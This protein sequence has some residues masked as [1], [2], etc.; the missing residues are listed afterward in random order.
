MTKSTFSSSSYIS[1]IFNI[2]DYLT[3]YFKAYI[4][5]MD[6]N[7]LKE[8]YGTNKDYGSL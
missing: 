6:I 8:I 5:Q 2:T 4:A 7:C 1:A 3:L